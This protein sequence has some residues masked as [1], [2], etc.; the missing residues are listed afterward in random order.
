VIRLLQEPRQVFT[1]KN[2]MRTGFIT[3]KSELSKKRVVR[4]EG[5]QISAIRYDTVVIDMGNRDGVKEGDLL[6]VFAVGDRVKHPDT[7]VDYGFVVRIKGVLRAISVGSTSSRCSVQDTFDPLAVNDP[8][9][10]YRLESGSMFDAWVKPETTIR[11]VVLAVN[12][13]ML[14]IHTN[15]ILYIDKGTRDNVQPGDHFTVFARASN[16]DDTGH[17]TPTGELEA[18]RVMPGETAVIVLSLKGE[19]INIGDRV[20][21]T[22][23]C[24]LVKK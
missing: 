21:L 17:R 12:E 20:E 2:F 8:V 22:A 18:I 4:I 24:K 3:K 23:R 10:K 19:A 1:E 15:D 5:E 9:M 13:P 6:A 7:G 11:G 16:L 14:S